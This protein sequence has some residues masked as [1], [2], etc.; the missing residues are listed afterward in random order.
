MLL[1]RDNIEYARQLK[2]K[3]LNWNQLYR[4]IVGEFKKYPKNE[5]IHIIPL[6]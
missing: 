1:T 4:L 2:D 6:F 5:D 3:M